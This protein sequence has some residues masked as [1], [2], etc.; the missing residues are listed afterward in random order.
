[1]AED[2]AKHQADSHARV[3][4]AQAEAERV[5]A[6]AKRLEHAAHRRVCFWSY[7]DVA[8][9]FPAAAFA[10]ASGAAGLATPDL[11][12][13]AA[14]LA[15]VSAGF[16][17]GAGFLRS[18]VRRAVNRRSRLA[19]AE[20]EAEARLLLAQGTRLDRESTQQALRNL[21]DSRTK[22]IATH[23]GDGAGGAPSIQ[24]YASADRVQGSLDGGRKTTS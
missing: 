20:V 8:L 24:Q 18:D 4:P 9:G 21:L 22:A 10:G 15:L 14:L 3:T 17:A 1:M 5:L 19:W 23:V 2:Y 7:I 12:V 13:P 16:T 11:R 6:E